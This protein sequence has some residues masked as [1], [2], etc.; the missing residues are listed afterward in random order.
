M[1]LAITIVV[2]R[3]LVPKIWEGL[4]G[5]I[6]QFFELAQVLMAHAETVVTGG[7]RML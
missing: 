5:T 6:V 3:L 1:G 4:E 7:L 2:L